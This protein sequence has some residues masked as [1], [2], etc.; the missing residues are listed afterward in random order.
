MPPGTYRFTATSD[1]GIRVWLDG[2]L[3]IDEWYDHSAKTVNVDRNLSAGHHLVTVEYYENTGGAVAK[4]SLAPASATITN[5]RGEYFN[6]TTLSGPPAMVRDDAQIDFN[7]GGG[8]PAPGPIGVDRFSVRW[9]RTLNLP[10]GSYRF[11]MT[12]DDGGRLWVNNH[13]LLDAWRD[14]APTTYTGDIYVPGGGVPVR[15]E[16]YENGAGAVARLQWTAATAPPPPPPATGWFGQYYPN[17]DLA[18]PPAFTR[19]DPDLRFDWGNGAP[20][21]GFPAD[22]FSIR[23]VRDIYFPAGTY[24]FFAQHDDG[25]RLWVD[26]ALIIDAWYD[27][28]ATPRSRTYTIGDGVHRFQVEYYEHADRASIVLGVGPGGAPPPPP[29]PS[30]GTEVLVDN[31]DAGFQWGGPLKS[32]YVASQG[33]GGN[34]YWTYNSTNQPYNYGKWMPRLPAAGQYEIWVYLPRDYGNSGSVRYRILH[35]DWRH[36]RLIN[37]NWY[38]DQWVSLGTYGFNGANIGREFVLVYDNTG[39]PFTSRTIAFDA[40]KFVLVNRNL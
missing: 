23:W 1:D 17:R 3:I 20:A 37:Q 8:S 27:Q 2:A 18:G 5:W 32:R 30:S 14:Q 4:A 28:S 35:N 22:N 31:T 21:P 11:D 38:S 19:V 26:G 12:V 15:M 33:I 7:W 10:P 16:Y 6:N 36:D 34:L 29:P 24:N 25:M 9:T 39:E 40:I 13:L